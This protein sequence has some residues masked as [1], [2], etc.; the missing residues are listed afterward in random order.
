MDKI[1]EAL[2]TLLPENQVKDV[3]K[4]VEEMLTEAKSELE[5]DFNSKL[6]D[7]Y[8][9]LSGELK[10]AEKTAETGYSE[11]WGIIQDLRNRLETQRAEFET[12]L[13]E[14]YEEAYQMLLAERGKNE[15]VETELYKQ[16]DEKLQEMKGFIIDKVNE[17]LQ[18]KGK[19]I[20]ENARRDVLTDPRMAEHKVTLEKVVDTIA[21]YISD[22]DYALAT[23][24]KLEAANKSLEELKGQ[25]KILEARSIRISTENTKLTEQVR[26]S[27]ELLKEHTVI[28]TNSDKNE[29][30]K[31]AEN[32]QGRGRKVVENVEVIGEP[33]T[34]EKT[35]EGDDTLAEGFDG[36]SD[37]AVLSG[38]KHND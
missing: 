11:A 28:A 24:S 27:G 16:Y 4:A 36:H 13:E 14:G 15:N 20:Y 32:V 5:A 37:W 35:A 33:K 22:E 9:Q 12:A 10:D 1:L 18:Y 31:K 25:V 8:G 29:R 34:S 23:N 6:E 3:A 17:F 21:D 19:E 26:K 30:A 2:S 7:A 38:L